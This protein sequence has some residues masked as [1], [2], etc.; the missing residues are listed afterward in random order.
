MER[1]LNNDEL[2]TA[3]LGFKF[4]EA[5]DFEAMSHNISLKASSELASNFTDIS[6]IKTKFFSRYSLP[7]KED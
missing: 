3:K 5:Y 6:Y 7:I 2:C 1:A 4:N